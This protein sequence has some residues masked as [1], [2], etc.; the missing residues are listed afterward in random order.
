MR[1]INTYYTTKL[2]ELA[3]NIPQNKKEIINILEITSPIEFTYYDNDIYLDVYLY[4]L[5]QA[6]ETKIPDIIKF[7]ITYVNKNASTKNNVIRNK[8]ISYL[9]AIAIHSQ[10]NVVIEIILD[11]LNTISTYYKKCIIEVLIYGIKTSNIDIIQKLIPN[12]SPH[13]LISEY[14]KNEIRK[15][16]SLYDNKSLYDTLKKYVGEGQLDSY[17]YESK[18]IMELL[19]EKDIQFIN[20]FIDSVLKY[21]KDDYS[22]F[23]TYIIEALIRLTEVGI[24]NPRKIEFAQFS[25]NYIPILT[26][27]YKFL[28]SSNYKVL[29]KKIQPLMSLLKNISY[30]L[31]TDNR[32]YDFI[33]TIKNIITTIKP[34]KDSSD[35][36]WEEGV[37]WVVN[38]LDAMID[39]YEQ[40]IKKTQDNIIGPEGIDISIGGT[41]RI[42]TKHTS[43]QSKKNNPTLYYYNKKYYKIH[44]GKKGGKYILIGAEK[45][46]KYI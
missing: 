33:R 17:I 40:N 44:H 26:I 19:F 18:V 45:I 36:K 10:N 32:L 46:K 1:I 29:Y 35:K 43:K 21:N 20:Q 38:Q 24:E 31:D 34:E 23:T 27:E 11:N 39:N 3:K 25:I 30:F 13:S 4:I 16:E 22:A 37:D 6:I 12:I 42:K 15:H 2:Q 28:D 41:N 8:I 9:I 14:E 7:Y 5:Q